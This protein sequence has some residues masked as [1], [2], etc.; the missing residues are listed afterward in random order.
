M[1][2][3]SPLTL[4]L[5][6][7]LLL[8]WACISCHTQKQVVSTTSQVGSTEISRTLAANSLIDLF[9]TIIFTPATSPTEATH[10]PATSP[11]VSLPFIIRRHAQL[12]SHATV[13]DTTRQQAQLARTDSTTRLNNLYPYPSESFKCVKLVFSLVVVIIIVSIAIGKFMVTR[14]ERRQP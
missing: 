7:P 8:Q 10:N 3:R 12:T 5:L 11:A 1:N 2:H 13:S 4:L 14:I 9:D 6:C